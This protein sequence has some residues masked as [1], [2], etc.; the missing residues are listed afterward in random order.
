MDF[1]ALES[2][3]LVKRYKR[4]LADVRLAKTGEL[5]CAHCP[6]TG[7][8][9]GCQPPGARG[10]CGPV[11]IWIDHPGEGRPAGGSSQA[12]TF[13]NEF[14]CGAQRVGRQVSRLL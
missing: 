13:S 14:G 8:M 6:N 3:Q 10:A 9:T 11:C 4:F 5:I 1:A 2:G 12:H 7:A